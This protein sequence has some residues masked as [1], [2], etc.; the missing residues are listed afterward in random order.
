[1][2][3]LFLASFVLIMTSCGN[4]VEKSNPFLGVTLV[5]GMNRADVE[6]R[7]SELSGAPLVY[8]AYGNNLRGGSIKYSL[9]NWILEVKYKA[10]TVGIS[11]EDDCIAPID[12]TVLEYKVYRDDQE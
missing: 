8:S 5:E 9:N 11:L 10:G 6:K 3:K 1:M 2:R 12:E 7:Y 4:G